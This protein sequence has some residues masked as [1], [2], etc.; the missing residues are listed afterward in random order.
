VQ[1]KNTNKHL[2]SF[3]L[4]P[5]KATNAREKLVRKNNGGD[6]PMSPRSTSEGIPLLRGGIDWWKF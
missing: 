3:Y 5:I 4:K 6:E 1:G 2:K